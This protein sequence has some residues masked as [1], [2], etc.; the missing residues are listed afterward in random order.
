M[1]VIKASSVNLS[2]LSLSD[3]RKFGQNGV[4]IVFANYDGQNP[5]HVQTPKVDVLWD[6]KYYA[7]SETKGKYAVQFSMPNIDS[8]KE[9]GSFHSKMNEMDNMIIDSAF[10]NRVAWFKGG[11]KLSRDTIETLY[12]PMVKLSTDSDTGEPD[13]KFPPKFQFKIVKKDNKHECSVYNSSRVEYNIDDEDA[14]NY[15]NLEDVLTKGSTM[16]IILKCNGV[17]IINNK[18]GCTWR[19]E[20]VMVT[21]KPS[22]SL[23]GCAFIKDDDD[24][25]SSDVV[26]SGVVDSDTP[27][28]VDSD[29][30]SSEEEPAPAPEPAAPKKK[31]RRAVKKA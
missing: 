17:W 4:Q 21:T 14:D 2:K 6:A 18:F 31:V 25:V 26:D 15:V 27:V 12:T 22:N 11:A 16:N 3:P 29:N 8:D 20:Q 24:E 30:D 9:M 28:Q 7:D 5:L 23:S 19:A 10:E 1:P 13:G